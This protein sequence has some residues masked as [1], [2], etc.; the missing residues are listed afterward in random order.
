MT[1]F[2]SP[3]AKTRSQAVVIFDALKNTKALIEFELC[4]DLKMS[5]TQLGKIIG[6]R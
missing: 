2:K 4:N 3:S 1:E 5:E 6:V